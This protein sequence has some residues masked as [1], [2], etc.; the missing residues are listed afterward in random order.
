MFI[1]DIII[2][3]LAECGRRRRTLFRI[4]ISVRDWMEKIKSNNESDSGDRPNGTY[5]N[6]NLRLNAWKTPARSESLAICTF[7]C[8]GMY[9]FGVIFKSI[10]RSATN[11]MVIRTNET[12]KPTARRSFNFIDRIMNILAENV[13]ILCVDVV[14]SPLNTETEKGRNDKKYGSQSVDRWTIWNGP[15]SVAQYACIWACLGRSPPSMGIHAQK[16]LL[17]P[18]LLFNVADCDAR[19]RVCVCVCWRRVRFPF[20]LYKYA[21]AIK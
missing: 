21:R 2:T 13:S 1:V 17:L 4:I 6:W 16:S 15:S 3:D 9:C 10:C 8:I 20:R 19:R 11:K 14:H 7:P 18:F 12:P 5:P